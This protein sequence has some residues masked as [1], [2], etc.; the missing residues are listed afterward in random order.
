MRFAGILRF[1]LAYQLR[2]AWPWL[3][4]AV[5]VV[6]AL[7]NTRVAIVPVT[8]P[9]DFI[10]NSP[11]IIAAV[12][13]FS[14]QIWL[15]L[16]PAVS[17]EAAARDVHTGMYPL[18]YASPVGK[19]EYLGGRFLAALLLQCLILLGVQ[20]G[21]L[22]AVHGPG[23][24][25]DVVGPFRP[26]AY[27]AA[28]G[29]IALPNALIATTMQFS[30]A[31][32]TGRPMAAYVGSFALFFLSYPV[33]LFLY[34]SKLA[35]P[36]IAKLSDPIGVFAIM[37]EMMSNW[38][39]VE[40]NV[41][42]F[43]LDG[44]MLINRLVWIGISLLV[45][46]VVYLRFRFAHR[47]AGD[48]L[49]R[50]LRRLRGTTPASDPA[51][52][53]RM[54]IAVP[55]VRGS[56]G[57]ATRLHQTLAIARSSF[58]AIATSLPGLFLLAAYPAML[59]FIMVVELQ[60]WGVPLLPKTVEIV[61]RYLTFPV[62]DPINYLVMAPL[63]V[64]FFA[65]EL[66]WRERDA[67]LDESVDATPVPEWV[68]FHGKYLGLALVLVALTTMMTMAGVVTQTIRGYHDFELA[69][70]VTLLFGFQLP[71][72]LLFA[73]LALAIQVVV[74]HKYLGQLAALVAYLA[75]IFADVLGIELADH[76]VIGNGSFVSLKQRGLL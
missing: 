43:T 65:G 46:A 27:L 2:R 76:V 50:L 34:V 64:V 75:L 68:L 10:L 16:A 61:S 67:R 4:M 63:L 66:V 36:E 31:L 33:T 56:F 3:S 59:V 51:A 60:Q 62:T 7:L 73:M 18:V 39:I 15:L 47:T 20:L 9:E 38:T 23:A 72:Y 5:L 58:R 45:L 1:E 19:A 6:F 13:V 26:A 24:N 42:M 53:A 21:S 35:K 74:D 11:F 32:L 8:L 54:A 12:T 17:G 44:S 37:N 28:Y 69:R 41:R 71:D 49:S 48:P 57:L 55:R 70:Y 29:F 40:K 25:P 30:A 52:P 22:L 14:C